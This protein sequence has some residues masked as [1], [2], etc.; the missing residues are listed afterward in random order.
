MPQTLSSMAQGN[1]TQK[2]RQ[3]MDII[4]QEFTSA[5]YPRSGSGSGDCQRDC[6]KC[7]QPCHI[8]G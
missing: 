7:A 2:Q 5:G 1:Y 4:E 3:M 6:G 8:A